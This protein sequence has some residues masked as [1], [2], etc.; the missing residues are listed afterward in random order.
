MAGSVA[1][2]TCSQVNQSWLPSVRRLAGRCR[3][4]G[5]L[6]MLSISVG[7]LELDLAK[8][9]AWGGVSRPSIADPSRWD[10]ETES[11]LIDYFQA[12]V[13]DR[14]IETFR[15]RVAARYTEATLCRLLSDSPVITARRAAAVS[16]GLLGNI[17]RCNAALGQALRDR[18]SAVRKMA[19]QSL[20]AVW[21]RGDTPE[22][23]R[24]LQQVTFL[25]SQ[26]QLERA[27]A[28]STRLISL[29]PN[30]AEAYNQRA[31]IY[32]QQGR[33]AESA[34]DCQRVL[35][36]NPYHIGA[37]SGLAQCQFQLNRP[38]EG[39]ET[40]RRALKLQPYD[41]G[42]RQTIKLLEVRAASQDRP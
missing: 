7:S 6:W 14:D 9:R 33:F 1:P 8:P 25:I 35:N 23:N 3:W 40:L 29:A 42:L 22:H 31:I 16:L 36:R 39:L 12:L 2:W 37:I 30:F 18:D 15:H 21:F 20:W 26:G 24:M 13:N 11:L 5:F 17:Q 10:T 38:A 28:L 41:E 4:I 27:E 34:Q 32:F 19:E